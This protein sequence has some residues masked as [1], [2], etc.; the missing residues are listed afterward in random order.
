[1][2]LCGSEI[3]VHGS[4]LR[5]LRIACDLS[6]NLL[7]P[8]TCLILITEYYFNYSMWPGLVSN[9]YY[10]LKNYKRCICVVTGQEVS[11]KICC[12]FSRTLQLL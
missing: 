5:G 8:I 11:K 6:C 7:G 2:P 1:M 4:R 3:L 10:N 9:N 12:V